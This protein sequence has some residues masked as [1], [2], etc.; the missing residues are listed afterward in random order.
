MAFLFF[1]IML[2]MCELAFFLTRKDILSPVFIYFSTFALSTF[3]FAINFYN[4]NMP[5]HADT[6]LIL[7][8][9]IAAFGIGSFSAYFSLKRNGGKIRLEKYCSNNASYKVTEINISTRATLLLSE[10]IVITD[11]WAVLDSYRISILAG[12]GQ[13]ILHMLPFVRQVTLYSTAD[14]QTPF[15]LKQLKYFC[16]AVAFFYL[17][18]LAYD[19]F[20]LKKRFRF[21]YLLP[22]VCEIVQMI[23]TTGRIIFL[24]VIIFLLIVSVI[25]YRKRFGWNKKVI[26]KFI[27]YAVIGGVAFIVVFRLAGI[28]TGKSSKFNFYD[29]IC[30]YLGG[31]LPAF[32]D[33]L[34]FFHQTNSEFGAETLINFQRIL[35]KLHITR[36]Y[37]NSALEWITIYDMSYNTYTALRRYFHDFGYLGLVLIQTGIG[38]FYSRFYLFTSRKEK[39]LLGLLIFGFIFYPVVL[40]FD[41]DLLFISVFSTAT[42]TQIFYMICI[43]WFFIGRKQEKPVWLKKLLLR[44]KSMT[45][46][47][48]IAIGDK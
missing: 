37:H 31:S 23:L 33:Y 35:Y 24:R 2:L 32:D 14:V 21:I 15:L 46:P 20:Y 47:N 4:W 10:I 6:M 22:P 8:V 42:V 43:Y 36:A 39:G 28:L 5:F 25:M 18:A 9:G 16:L 45:S 3:A 38:F 27:K 11:I 48:K 19:V 44:F 7:F 26:K 29:N 13:G 17:F 34:H 40:S 30:L 12:N 1:S 41:D